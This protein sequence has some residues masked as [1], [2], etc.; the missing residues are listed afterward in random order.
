M[1]KNRLPQDDKFYLKKYLG[2]KLNKIQ[3]FESV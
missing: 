2:S 3:H 1:S